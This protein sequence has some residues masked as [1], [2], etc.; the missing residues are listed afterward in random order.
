MSAPAETVEQFLAVLPKPR[1]AAHEALLATVR[2]HLPAGFAERLNYGMVSWVTDGGLAL[3]SLADHGYYGALYV[4][5][6]E[7]GAEQRLYARWR[8]TGTPLETGSRA[9]RFRTRA[10][11]ALEVV[12]EFVAA[13]DAAALTAAYGRARRR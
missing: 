7:P 5:C 10:E 1:R 13:G 2:D 3:V 4:N 11:L 8:A 6:V 12:A 9:I